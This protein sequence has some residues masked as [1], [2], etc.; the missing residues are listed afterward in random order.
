LILVSNKRIIDLE[1]NKYD[2]RISI[3]FN[4]SPMANNEK[5]Y[6]AKINYDSTEYEEII[7]Y[8][9]MSSKTLYGSATLLGAILGIFFV[10]IANAVQKRS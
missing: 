4:S 9:S 8:N 2:E 10:L 6:A 7:N 3:M 1:S 5:F